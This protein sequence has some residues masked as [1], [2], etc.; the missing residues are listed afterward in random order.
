MTELLLTYKGLTL[1]FEKEDTILVTSE[2][3]GPL[4]GHWVSR[5]A[6][7]NIKHNEDGTIDLTVRETAERLTFR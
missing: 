2:A 6:I 5:L 1:V 7:S 4:F 3:A